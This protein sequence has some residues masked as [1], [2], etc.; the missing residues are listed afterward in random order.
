ML[1]VSFSQIMSPPI[2]VRMVLI[3][4]EASLAAQRV[5]IVIN[6]ACKLYLSPSPSSVKLAMLM[7][8]LWSLIRNNYTD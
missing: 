7:M 1:R 4:P 6:M 8:C 5:M 2:P 3:R